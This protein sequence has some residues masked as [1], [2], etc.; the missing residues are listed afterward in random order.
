MEPEILSEEVLPPGA[1]W[2]KRIRRG[3][4]LRLETLGPDGNISALIYNAEQPLDRLNLPDTLKALHT[5]KLHKGHVLMSDMGRALMSIVADSTGWH[6]PLGGVID[7]RQVEEK[8]G[9][10]TFQEARNKFHRNGWDNF[11]IELGKHGLGEADVVANLNFFSKVVVDE[12]GRM[13]LE[14]P[15]A[16]SGASVEL[17]A[18]LDVLVVLS[19]TPHPMAPPAAHY[20]SPP[21]RLVLMAGDVAG[22][23]DYCRHYRPECGRA[24]QMTEGY[25]L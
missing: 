9:R 19:N 21:V 20:P 22:P 12:Q 17:R 7:A 1:M 8:F 16:P 2:S 25:L 23:D 3:R 24:L 14:R 18:D 6:D 13:H 5:A 4:R 15:G 11:L 10:R